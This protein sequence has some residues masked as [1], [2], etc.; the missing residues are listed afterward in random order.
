MSDDDVPYFCWDRSWNVGEIRRRL[1]GQKWP[2]KADLAAWIMREAAFADVWAFLS[3]EE[4]GSHMSVLA[5]R[6]G[7]RRELWEYIVR[8][9]NEL[10]KLQ[11]DH[12]A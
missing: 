2:E 9:W 4:V 7:R 8:T 5:P 10:G 6:L 1:A 11:G 3:P 12:A